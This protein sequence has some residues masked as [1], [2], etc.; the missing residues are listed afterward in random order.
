[1]PQFT[2]KHAEAIAG[3]LGCT[4]K[5]GKRHRL[6]QL[7]HEGKLVMMFGIRRGSREEGHDYLPR[8][9][10][11]TPKQCRELRDCTLSKEA[12]LDVLKQKSLL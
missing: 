6:A 11:L 12:Y 2:G 4:I 8:Q 7:R 1:M 3:K 10:H 5:E 9:L